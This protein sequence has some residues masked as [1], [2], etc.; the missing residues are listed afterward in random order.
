MPGSLFAGVKTLYCVNDEIPAD[1]RAV[2]VSLIGDARENVA[3]G[4]VETVQS[5]LESMD[6]VARNKL[7]PGDFREKFRHGCDQVSQVVTDDPATAV[8]YL[9]S[10][11]TAVEESTWSGD[12]DT[13][14]KSNSSCD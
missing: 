4:N 11:E 6:T 9:R 10:M 5:E 12:P 2:F 14:G 3:A 8:E 1:V 13:S 7:P